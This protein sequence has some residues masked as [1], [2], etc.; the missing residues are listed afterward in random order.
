MHRPVENG[1]EALYGAIVVGT[2]CFLYST[3]FGSFGPL[4]G[5]LGV[6]PNVISIGNPF[7]EIM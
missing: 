4:L 6:S 7:N 5:R 2:T 1:V 3:S